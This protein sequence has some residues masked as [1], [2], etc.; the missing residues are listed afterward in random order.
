MNT[1][2]LKPAQKFLTF[3]KRNLVIHTDA[4]K[5]LTVWQQFRPRNS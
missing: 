3:D 2:N 5:A 4:Q 1:I